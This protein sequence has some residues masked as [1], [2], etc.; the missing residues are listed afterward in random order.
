[1]A[2]FT[3]AFRRWQNVCAIAITCGALLSSPVAV[4]SSTLF[5]MTPAPLPGELG[6]V[7][8]AIDPVKGR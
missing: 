7:P 6:E 4:A 1:M 3:A 5:G 2:H 8:A